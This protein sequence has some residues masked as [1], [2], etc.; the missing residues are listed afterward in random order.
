MGFLDRLFGS[1]PRQAPPVPQNP[2]ARQ[3]YPTPAQAAQPPRSEDEVAVERYRYLLRTAP[4]ETIEQVHAEAFAKLSPDQ[5]QAVLAELKAGLPPA[6]QP[7]SS[8][9]QTL[10]RAATRAEYM[11]PG[12]MER[13][14]QRSGGF[15]SSMGGSIVGTVIGY[16]IGSALVSS[17]M[18]PSGYEQ[19]YADGSTDA[20]GDTGADGSGADASGADASGWSGDA[21]GWGGDSGSADFGGDFGGDFGF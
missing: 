17:F 12:F 7:Q 13:T 1:Q 15:G 4:P 5:R 21:S 9:P 14:T 8:D 16:V 6:E 11:Q 19:G 18:G 20:A 3:G 2:Y 10:A